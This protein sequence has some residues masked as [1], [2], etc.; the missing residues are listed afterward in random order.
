MR[1]SRIKKKI[2]IAIGAENETFNIHFFTVQQNYSLSF[3]MLIVHKINP[4]V[5]PTIIKDEVKESETYEEASQ[6]TA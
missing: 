6:N 5:K 1:S 2:R 3:S 4:K